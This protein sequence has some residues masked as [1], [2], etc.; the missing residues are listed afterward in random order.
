MVRASVSATWSNVLWSSLRTIT[1]Q[2]PPSP[3]SGPATSGRS[4]VSGISLVV[5]RAIPVAAQPG[6]LL[7]DGHRLPD[8]G[9]FTC[10]R[11]ARAVGGEPRVLVELPRTRAEVVEVGAHGVELGAH[12]LE[13]PEVRRRDGVRVPPLDQVERGAPRLE[14]DVGRRRR[15]EYGAVADA[16]AGG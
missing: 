4:M 16:H 7:L 12:V 3:L 10:R 9:H 5:A 6:V 11:D 2:A 13:A 14:V 8:G 1:R 15:R